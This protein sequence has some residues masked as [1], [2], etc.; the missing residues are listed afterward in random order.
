[1]DRVA[2][3]L[4]KAKERQGGKGAD[5]VPPEGTGWAA[6]APFAPDPA[7]MARNRIVTF[8]RTDPACAA[9]EML[10]T[11]LLLLARQ[12]GW[13]SVGVT[14]PTNGCGKTTTSLNLAFSLAQL[15]LRVLLV[16]LDLRRPA[17]ARA[18]GLSAPHSM[19]G[20]L[21]GTRDAAENF[22]RCGDNLA[23]GSNAEPVRNSADLLHGHAAAEAVA[24]LKARFAPD[25]ILY[26]L[27]PMLVADDA[28]AFMPHLDGVLLV[29]AA[30]TTRPDEV[31]VC[32]GELTQLCGF[33]GIV[34]N[35]CRDAD[36][37]DWRPGGEVVPLRGS[38][39]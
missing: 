4:R 22:V 23:I 31:W 10:R 6:L 13:T 12:R 37:D 25:L 33:V 19:A 34:V 17:V 18:I 8:G 32:H 3:G 7:T 24:G 36:G 14:S 9:F 39:R 11:R 1:M 15:Q 20:V 29:V 27:P 21:K 38:G 30:G 26:D 28:L 35:K 2:A 16:D 5:A